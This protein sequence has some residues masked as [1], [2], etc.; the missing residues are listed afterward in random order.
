MMRAWKVVL[1]LLFLVA[2]PAAGCVVSDPDRAAVR[3][4]QSG[5]DIVVIQLEGYPGDGRYWT[6]TAEPQGI[7][8]EVAFEDA[9]VVTDNGDGTVALPTV[10]PAPGTVPFVFTGAREGEV[11][12]RFTYADPDA[13]EPQPAGRAEFTIRVLPDLKLHIVSS[14]R[15]MELFT[16]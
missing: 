1:A 7:V 3:R 4:L 8:R 2:L 15:E 11:E 6:C 16:E 9:Y 12:L 5:E 13:P 10:E 14:S